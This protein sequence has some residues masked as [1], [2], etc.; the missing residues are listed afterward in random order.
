MSSGVG[1]VATLVLGLGLTPGGS[2]TPPQVAANSWSSLI[3]PGLNPPSFTIDTGRDPMGQAS[4]SVIY[5]D[6]YRGTPNQ[7]FA[8]VGYFTLDMSGSGSLGF[9]PSLSVPEPSTFGLLIC[10]VVLATFF[11]RF[12][13]GSR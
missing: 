10:G 5:E 6:L 1:D 12:Q 2:A 8:Y 13:R 4:S 9:T 11:R 7:P 3:S